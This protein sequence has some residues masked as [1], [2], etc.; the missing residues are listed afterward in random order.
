MADGRPWRLGEATSKP[1]ESSD[2]PRTVKQT[3]ATQKQTTKRH[4]ACVSPSPDRPPT[5][6]GKVSRFSKHKPRKKKQ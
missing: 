1:D 5:V 2:I 3:S 4:D 6:K